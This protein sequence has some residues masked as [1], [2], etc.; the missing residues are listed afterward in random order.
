MSLPVPISPARLKLVSH[1]L[2]GL[3]LLLVL[4]LHLLPALLAGLLVYA[5]V[6]ALAPAVQKR[7][8]G[9]HA[10]WLV[11]ALL[12]AVVVGLLTFM[13]VVAIAYLGSEHGNP[14][15]LFERLTPLIERAR[16]QLPAFVDAWLPENVDEIRAA[17]MEW[18]RE[19][20]AQLQVAGQAAVRVT[21]QLLIGMIL[22]AMLSLHTARLRPPGGP[23]ADAL[24]E[25][26]A[27]LVGSFHD[28]VFAQV[29]ISALNTLFTGLFLLV[30]L[31][32]FGVQLPLA[33]SLVVATFVCGLLPVVG[34]LISNTLIFIVGM[35]VSPWV[36]VTALG[37]LIVIHKLEYFLNARIIG[38]QIRS[39]AWELLIAM[40]AMEAAFGLG[41]VVAAPIYYA[42]LKREL[43]SAKLI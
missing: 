33:K 1:V 35:S 28:I 10:H 12:A 18:L 36:A 5:L 25:R 11:V 21:V 15:V 38:T 3:G 17:I 24:N 42:Y 20:A 2:M 7:L 37:Y 26:C 39:R 23:L 34:N 41:G 22:G 30:A 6:N 32:L 40:L 16:A 4:H 9:A 13:I 29:K 8:P 14:S 43:E 19:H 27:R 31:P